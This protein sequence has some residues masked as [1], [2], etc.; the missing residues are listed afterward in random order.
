M[1]E[2]EKAGVGLRLDVDRTSDTPHRA[3]YKLYTGLGFVGENS[4]R[5]KESLVWRPKN[6][7]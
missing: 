3:L 5:D 1:E 2:A 7:R 4:P 6:S